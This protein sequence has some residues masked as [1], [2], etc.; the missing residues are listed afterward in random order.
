VSSVIIIA[1]VAYLVAQTSKFVLARRRDPLVTFSATGGMPSG[2]SATIV[3]ATTVIGLSEG[4]NSSLFGLAVVI[5]AL[6]IHDAI[7]LRWAVGEQARRI[8]ELLG[9]SSLANRTRLIVWRGHR[10]REVGV[11]AVLGFILAVVLYQ[12]WYA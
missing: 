4:L 12:W 7:R 5:S 9:V 6:V 8:N 2:H 11:G 10:L 1:F 3:A